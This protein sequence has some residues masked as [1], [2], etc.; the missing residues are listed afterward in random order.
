MTSRS[1]TA[2]LVITAFVFVAGVLVVGQD[3][4]TLTSP[5]GI[6]FAEFKGY[7]ARQVIA[8]SQLDSGVKAIVGNPVMIK[9]LNEGIPAT[10][11]PVPDGAVMAKIEWSA[12]ENPDLKG[13]RECLRRSKTWAS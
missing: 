10:G 11:Q 12:R 1:I 9:A 3:R 4:F 7:D 6:G 13:E 5:D 2:S 8:P